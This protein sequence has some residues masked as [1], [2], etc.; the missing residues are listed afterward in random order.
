ML[1]ALEGNPAFWGLEWPTDPMW[2]IRARWGDYKG[3]WKG[4]CKFPD[5][6]NIYIDDMHNDGS[7][8]KFH[9]QASESQSGMVYDLT[10]MLPVGRCYGKDTYYYND[11]YNKNNLQGYLY[12]GCCNGMSNDGWYHTRIRGEYYTWTACDLPGAFCE[13]CYKSFIDRCRYKRIGPTDDYAVEEW[14]SVKLKRANYWRV[15]I[16]RDSALATEGA[17]E[18]LEKYGSIDCKYTWQSDIKWTE[19]QLKYYQDRLETLR[20]NE[21]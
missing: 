17:K 6:I 8:R 14:L 21:L 5:G 18:N 12:C 15:D 7:K 16:E 19:V 9:L 1:T 11:V 20:R 2:W 3:S 13:K 4:N 10:D